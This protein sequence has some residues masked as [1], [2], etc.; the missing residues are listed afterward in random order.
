M[1]DIVTVGKIST[2]LVTLWSLI[3]KC[4]FFGS[5]Y[6]QQNIQNLTMLCVI[7]VYKIRKLY[8]IV[9]STFYVIFKPNFTFDQINDNISSSPAVVMNSS[10]SKVRLKGGM[11]IL[12][13]FQVDGMGI[14]SHT[15]ACMR[16]AWKHSTLS[17]QY[18]IQ[19]K[20]HKLKTSFTQS[21]DYQQVF[22][23]NSERWTLQTGF[24]FWKEKL[25]SKCP[26]NI[27]DIP[28]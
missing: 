26:C 24:S 20:C 2:E 28:P 21:C 11:S 25:S 23:W 8:M 16:F 3:T 13:S 27:Y 6:T 14:G 18:F 10:N 4:C 17:P 1:L 19:Q 12:A 9:F 5:Y 7:K 15:N 22:S